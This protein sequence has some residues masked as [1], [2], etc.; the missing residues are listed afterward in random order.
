MTGNT[1]VQVCR[2]RAIRWSGYDWVMVSVTL[3]ERF[4]G[5]EE[6]APGLHRVSYRSK[7]L[8]YFEEKKLRITEGHGR[9]KRG[10]SRV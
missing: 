10:G 8:G 7:F 9:V 4:I 5:L 6:F 3:I 1:T 2:D